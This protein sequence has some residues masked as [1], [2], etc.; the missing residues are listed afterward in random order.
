MKDPANENEEMIC[1]FSDKAFATCAEQELPNSKFRN[2]SRIN[3]HTSTGETAVPEKDTFNGHVWALRLWGKFL[4]INLIQV[5][6]PTEDKIFRYGTKAYLKVSTVEEE[7]G[8]D[9]GISTHSLHRST[10]NNGLRIIQG[11]R[12]MNAE[13]TAAIRSDQLLT[14]ITI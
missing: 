4:N 3:V 12:E 14:F 6:A 2:I 7:G 1:S 11:G 10:K 5:H 9:S 8:P 13:I